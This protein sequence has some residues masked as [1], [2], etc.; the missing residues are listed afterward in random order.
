MKFVLTTIGS[1]G[2]VFPMI[3]LARTLQER[4]HQV[5]LA[6]NGAF[7]SVTERN[8][9]PFEPLGTAEDY[10][11]CIASPDLWHPT[12]SFQHVFQFFRGTL[13][14]Q[15]EILKAHAESGPVVGLSSCLC[16]GSRIAQEA[17]DI[18]VL[19]VHL[20]PSVIWSDL[21][22]PVVAGLSGPRWFKSVM[23]R[24]G[25]KLAVDRVVCPEL[26]QWRAEL[27][28][29]PVRRITRWWN[30]PTGVL[31]LFPDWYAAPQSD[32]PQPLIQTG[33]P[34]WNDQ[35]ETKSGTGLP[36]NLKQFLDSGTPPIA[37]TPGTA[38][39][40]GRAFFQTAMQVCQMLNR[41][42][43]FLTRY[44]E[45]LPVTL[46]EGILQVEY[47][48][49]DLLLPRCAAFVHHGG[50]GSTSQAFLAGV[51]QIAMPLAHD[52]FDNAARIT[53]LNAGRSLAATSFKPPVL[54]RL[55]K[56]ILTSPRVTAA[57]KSLQEKVAAR[58]ALHESVDA[59]ERRIGIADIR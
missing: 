57:C 47:A 6:T 25:E 8:G 21:E 33:F 54:T 52:Q 30:S 5:L 41:R 13:Q 36:D 18:P 11:R 50:I 49:L 32:W 23:F 59:I 4:G 22:P 28:L 58:N 29:P 24:L 1:A 27:S 9:I 14:R 51:P 19:T 10:H 17:L 15:F 34:L 16:F 2:D 35:S 20:Q 38:N 43:L 42:A 46:P 40:H 55:L 37:F 48:P 45:Q 56:D 31:C 39:R 26:N 7:K 53:S 12:R 3:G 44:T